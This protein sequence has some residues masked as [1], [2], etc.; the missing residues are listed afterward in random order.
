[1]DLM[2]GAHFVEFV[3]DLPFTDPGS[4][5]SVPGH[6]KDVLFVGRQRLMEYGTLRLQL[7]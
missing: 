5:L 6:E 2:W 4:I 7:S 1:M 3:V